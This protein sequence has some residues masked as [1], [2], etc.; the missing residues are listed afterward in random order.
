MKKALE[1]LKRELA[2]IRSGRASSTLLDKIMVEAYGT[3]MPLK[4][5]AGISTPEARLIVLQPFDKSTVQSIEKAIM[6]SDLGLTPNVDGNLIRLP[7]PQLTEERRKELVKVIKKKVEESKVSLRN[8][9]RDAND[10]LKEMEKKGTASE[11]DVR[12]S[13]EQIQ[14]MTDHYTKEMDQAFTQK[15]KEIMEV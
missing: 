2:T 13:Q 7:I 4:Q 14:K 11:D 15:E 3:Q 9:R 8:V 6:K 10:E 12:R 5:L 1:A